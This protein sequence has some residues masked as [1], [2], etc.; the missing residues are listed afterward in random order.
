MSFGGGSSSGGGGTTIQSNEPYAPAQP[1]LN[2]IISDASA[3]YGQGPQYVA[4]TTQ[5]MQGLAAQENLANLANTEI[6]NTIS[7]QYSN[8]FLS[9]LIA[10]VASSAYTNVAQ[11]FS[12]AG[13]TP[14]SPMSQ[15][16]V[17][18][19]VGR[20]ALPLAF[21]AYN[22][23]R[24]RQLQ[25]ARAVPSLTAVGE[26]LRSLQQEQNLAPYQNLQRFS[27]VVTPIASGFPVQQGTQ[28]FE[29]N[30]I[31][32]AA[33][34]ALTGAALGDMFGRP[35]MGAAIGGGFGLL[36]GLL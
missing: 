4:P 18:S 22:A 28:S 33:G 8:P 26:E 6:A 3:I 35:G 2:Q 25:T 15:Q 29:S 24:N 9:P 16:Q 19:Q 36:G 34:G 32:M 20:Q 27:N 12:G 11:Q 5:Q 31:G 14:G 21:Q 23:E 1:A 17:V 10:D 30:P 13:R 7:G